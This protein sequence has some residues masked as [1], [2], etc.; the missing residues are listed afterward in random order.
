M[1]IEAVYNLDKGTAVIGRL[2]SKIKVG[3]SVTVVSGDN[4]HESVVLGIEMYGKSL[5]HADECAACGV[6]LRS[7]PFV[8]TRD[9]YLAVKQGSVAG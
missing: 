4:K 7:V 5:D 6:L 3:D 9:S 1:S 8:Q 2:E